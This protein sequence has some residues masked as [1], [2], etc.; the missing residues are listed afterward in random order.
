MKINTI[1]KARYK[2]NTELVQFDKDGNERLFKEIEQEKLFEF[3]IIHN[4]KVI[5]VFP[6]TG[7]FGIN[8]FLYETDISN[9]KDKKYKLI[10]FT[11]RK[12]VLGT[13]KNENKYFIGFQI[14]I[15]GRNQKRLISIKDNEIQF[16][17]E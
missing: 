7:T 12:K 16:V 17:R 1:W 6:D 8:G 4:D 13:G 2:N 11:R 15:D 14:V 5:S 9:Q 10:N 3:Q